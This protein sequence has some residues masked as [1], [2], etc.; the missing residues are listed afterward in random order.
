MAKDVVKTKG[1]KELF[2]QP[3]DVLMFQLSDGSYGAVICVQISKQKG[4]QTYDMVATTYLEKQPPTIDT[5]FKYDI[6]GTKIGTS[7]VSATILAMQ[8]DVKEIW[9]HQNQENFFFGLPYLLITQKDMMGYYEKFT[10]IGK[11]Q[12]KPSLIKQGGYS[13]FSTFEKLERVFRDLDGH[14]RAFRQFQV[15]ISICVVGR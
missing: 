12:L 5:L 3:A 14:M 10:V 6:L 1:Q 9:Q 2:F 11:M 13:Y 15:P 4:Q 8:P 7:F